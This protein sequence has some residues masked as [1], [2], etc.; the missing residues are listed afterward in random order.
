MVD[1]LDIEVIGFEFLSAI[2]AAARQ[3]ETPGALMNVVGATMEE[4]INLRFITKTD[5]T[6]NAWLPLAASTLK[7]KKGVGSLLELSGLGKAS[8]GYVLGVDGL[9]VEVGFGESYMGYHET[10]TQK[11]PRRQLLT[12]DF[13]AG[14][15]G[16]QDQADILE[17]IESFLQGLGLNE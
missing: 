7:R 14:T 10:G 15:L 6:G 12:D 1:R 16:Q 8:L 2:D 5:P 11:M 17:D 4:N 9:S 13:V 3:L